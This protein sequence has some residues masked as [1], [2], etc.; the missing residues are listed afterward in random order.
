MKRDPLALSGHEHDVLVV[1]G[2]IAGAWTAYEAASRGL[3][4]A[5]IELGDF[6]QATSWS[7]LKTAHGGL[8]HLQRLDVAGFRESVAERRALLRVAPEVVRPLAFAIAAPSKLDQAKFFLGGVVND[9]LSFDRN[10]GVRE[11]R[12]LGASRILD[13]PAAELLG[14]GSL[15]SDHVFAWQDAQITHTERLLMGVLHAAVE[16]GAVILNHCRIDSATRTG[17]GFSVK[18]TDLIGSGEIAFSTRSAVNA[19]GVQ[20]EA[21]ARLFGAACDGPPLIR[22]VNVVLGRDL[23]PEVALGAKD[24]GRFLFLV[25]WLGHTMLGTI[26]DDGNRPV[27]DLVSELL[28]AGRR[29]FPWADIR[30][31]DIQ[32]VHSGH[33]PRAANGEPIYRSRLIP[34]GEAPLISILSAKYTTARATAQKAIED[35]GRRLSIPLRPSVSATTLLPMAAPLRG[36]LSERLLFAEKSE[37]AASPAEAWRGRLSEGASGAPFPDSSH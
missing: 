22:G 28:A 16:A 18:A 7:S 2:G 5:L 33:V 21:V 35:I 29:A 6:G 13:R 12:L 25:P 11:D 30:D 32:V 31:D 27:S 26:Y 23:S 8:R 36:S 1:G 20:L 17:T 3:R 34:G 24:Q 37:M 19:A 15:H 10:D 4:T 14:A 9:L